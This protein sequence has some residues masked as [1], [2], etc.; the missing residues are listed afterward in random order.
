MTY[1]S[2]GFNSASPYRNVS[3]Y[4]WVKQNEPHPNTSRLFY[5]DIIGAAAQRYRMK[6][7][8]TDFLCYRGPSMG[9]ISDVPAG[10]NGEHM[11]LGGM[12]EAA[13]DHGVETQM[14]MALAHQILMSAEWPGV[15][16]ARVNGD[17]G[18]DVGGLVVPAL[19][20]ATVG[21]GWSKD[22]LRTASRCYVPGLYPN[23]TVKWPCGSVNQG[24]GTSGQFKNQAQQTTLAALSL[25]PVGISDQLSSYPTNS[26]ATITSNVSLVMS[27]CSA[28]G[29]LL[30][31]SYP[32]TPLERGLLGEVGAGVQLWG[33]YTAVSAGGAGGVNVWFLAFAFK[34][35]KGPTG[36][37]VRV[38]E[39]DLA[40]MVDNQALPSPLF[41]D[42]PTGTFSGSGAHFPA[43]GGWVG[44]HHDPAAESGGGDPCSLAAPAP[45]AGAANF[46]VAPEGSQYNIAPVIGGVALLGEAGKVTAVSTHRFASAIPAPGGDGLDLA[47]RGKPGEHIT[48]LYSSDRGPCKSQAATVGPKG[49]TFVRLEPQ[50]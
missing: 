48:L 41:D 8:F 23:G 27:T 29:D 37:S 15:T 42:I 46:T 14:C 39:A 19:L 9:T 50:Q 28:S 33:T 1:Y 16:N 26:S 30:Q 2:N 4:K 34:L 43:V 35:G 45:W 7:L 10:E 49:T 3:E 38:L 21:L 25:G 13:A 40:P 17:G 11:W 20:A 12:V 5:S 24:E 18:L 22:N 44:W 36:A 32:L 47:L 31:P 6:M